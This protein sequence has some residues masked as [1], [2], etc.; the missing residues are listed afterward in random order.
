MLQ[1]YQTLR[2]FISSPYDVETERKLA[3]EVIFSIN[4]KCKEPL[5]ISLEVDRWENLSPSTPNPSKSRI[6]DELNE[7]VRNCNVFVL[8]LN[9]RYGTVEQGQTKSNT[10]REIQTALETLIKGKKISFLSYFCDISSNPDAG[11]Q[12]R[13]VLELRE[14]LTKKNIWF[15]RYRDPADFKDK[16]THDLYKTALSYRVSTSKHKALRNFWQLGICE[17][18]DHPRL[19]IIYPPVSREHMKHEDPDH[20]WEKRLAP[21]IVFED[22]KALQK[23]DKG[24]RLIGLS[25]FQI[26]STSSS[27]TDFMDRNRV[28]L[29]VPRNTLAQ[30]RLSQYENLLKFKFKPSTATAKAKLFWRRSLR[31]NWFEVRSPLSTYLRLQR[32][33]NPGGEWLP[34]MGRIIAKDYAILSRFTDDRGSTKAIDG[35]LKDYFI[36]GVRGLGTWGAGWFIDR[37]YEHFRKLRDSEEN[38]QFLLEVTY[39]DERIAEVRDVSNLPESYFQQQNK[40]T[41]IKKIIDAYNA[42]RR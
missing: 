5:G 16:L 38:L 32:R 31:K 3:E 34:Q 8:I 20:F 22:Y 9:R 30:Q 33:A 29:C 19:A 13:K 40:T 26:Y 23:L 4:Q 17:P 10:E 6:Q 35:T 27:P 14:E 37:E 42:S 36:A 15:S 11:E 28:W 12:E 1:T 24:L 7:R 21:H 39:R 18:L 2:I 25:H 41:E